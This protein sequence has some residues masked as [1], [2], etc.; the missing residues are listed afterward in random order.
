MVTNIFKIESN[1]THSF[2]VNYILFDS[3]CSISLEPVYVEGQLPPTVYN[4]VK[5]GEYRGEIKIG[6]TFTPEVLLLVKLL[7]F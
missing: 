3:I 6:L 5:D 2:L 1:S 4:V 7:L